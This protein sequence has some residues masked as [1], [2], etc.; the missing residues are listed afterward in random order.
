MK[1]RSI[2]SFILV[3]V[4]VITIPCSVFI[5]RA[6]TKE[7]GDPTNPGTGPS[8]SAVSQVIHAVEEVADRNYEI[9]KDYSKNDSTDADNYAAVLEV[10]KLNDYFNSFGQ[11][12]VVPAAFDYVFK[13]AGSGVY[14]NSFKLGQTYFSRETNGKNEYIYYFKAEKEGSLV[15]LYCGDQDNLIIC[16]VEYDF[17][18]DRL[19]T[20]KTITNGVFAIVD[21]EANYYTFAQFKT[22][23]PLQDVLDGNFSYDDITTNASYEKMYTGNIAKNINSIDFEMFEF[24]GTQTSK[25]IFNNYIINY[26]KCM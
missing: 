3:L 26:S 19:I 15:N 14:Q 5:Y 12:M 1:K 23:K 17:E 18:N 9:I 4:L 13:S 10:E 21:Y 2:I 16:Q 22:D 25:N 11:A 24:D 7:E 20:A 8:A 6:L